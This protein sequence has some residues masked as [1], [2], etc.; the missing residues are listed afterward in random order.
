MDVWGSRRCALNAN[1]PRM[2]NDF[3]CWQLTQ[4]WRAISFLRRA[5]SCESGTQDR[6]VEK[7]GG[8]GCESR[9]GGDAAGGGREVPRAF[10]SYL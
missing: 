1:T 4:Q 10:T 2:G 7:C 5:R 6:S 3:S 8:Q 9:G